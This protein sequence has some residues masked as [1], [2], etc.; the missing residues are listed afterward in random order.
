MQKPIAIFAGSFDPVTY[1][2][3]DIIRRA[4]EIFGPLVVLVMKNGAKNSLFSPEERV[5][6]LKKSVVNIPGVTVDTAQGLLADYA[7]K[8]QIKI[9]VRAIRS[10]DDTQHELAQ[11]HYNRMFDPSLETVFLAADQNKQL[12]SS[13]AVREIAR[14]GANVSA[15]VPPCVRT[16]L[17]QKFK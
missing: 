7:Q 4:R 9:L 6:L 16:A 10:S 8:H 11:A 3:V 13:S 2:H 14:C 12:I 5:E 17:E 15:L 1:G